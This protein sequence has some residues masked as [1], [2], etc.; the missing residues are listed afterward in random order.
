VKPES[1]R[2]AL[3][4]GMAAGKSSVG[5]ALAGLIGLPFVD[6]DD[7]IS[8]AA[9]MSIQAIFDAE[10]E[11]GFRS[12]ESGALAGIASRRGAFV[13]ACGGGIVL[14]PEN[15]AILRDGFFTVWLQVDA[16]EA[17][18][19]ANA[20]GAARPLLRVSDQL[21]E[22]ESIL[23]AR[24]ELYRACADMEFDSGAASDPTETAGALL[25]AI[26]ARRFSGAG[27]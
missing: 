21:T 5:K 19:R 9:A 17:L 4:G 20:Q 23:T 26:G 18:R 11:S 8:H 6:L 1:G 7:E 24:K 27:L 2:I 22:L 3:I 10:G 25:K 15:R 12:R 14:S 13:L 16:T